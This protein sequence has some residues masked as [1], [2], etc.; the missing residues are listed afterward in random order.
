M[1]TLANRVKAIMHHAHVPAEY[2]YKLFRDCCETAAI[3]DRLMIVEVNGKMASQFEHFAGKNPKCAGYSRTWGEAGTVK[4]YKKMSPQI[5]D[6]G[7]TCMIIGYSK[8]HA[9]DCYRMWDKET[10]GIHVTRDITWLRRM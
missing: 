3:L 2:C 1:A 4:I 9:H 7:V 8:N 10:G 6:C 5:Q